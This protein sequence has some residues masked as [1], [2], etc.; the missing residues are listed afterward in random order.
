[1]ENLYNQK[2]INANN[3]FDDRFLDVKILYLYS[4]N[5]LPSIHFISDIDAEKA[6]EAIREKFAENIRNIHQRKWYKRKKKRFEFDNSF[7]IMDNHC[8]LEFDNDWCDILH[9][10]KSREFV[11]SIVD[12][13]LQFKEKQRRQPL[14][15]NLIVQKGNRFNLKA[16]E[17]KRTKLDL[18]LF[19]EEDFRET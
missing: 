19:Y 8:V 10:G 16:M 1:M 2:V 11:Q 14:E 4:F 6:F 18:D 17:I 3:V 7:V 5:V 9:D 15:I 13:V 12:T